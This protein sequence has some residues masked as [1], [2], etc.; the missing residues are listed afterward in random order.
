MLGVLLDYTFGL[1]SLVVRTEIRLVAVVKINYFNVGMFP[2]M[3]VNR[4]ILGDLVLL[5]KMPSFEDGKQQ[6]NNRVCIPLA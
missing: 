2:D 1:Y 4:G 5:L 6:K 3:V